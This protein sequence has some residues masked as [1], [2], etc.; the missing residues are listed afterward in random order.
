MLIQ[1]AAA[2]VDRVHLHV[3]THQSIANLIDLFGDTA[4][5]TSVTPG[6]DVIT[7]SIT[8]PNGTTTTYVIAQSIVSGSGLIV[9]KEQ[10]AEK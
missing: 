3:H 5:V 4:N 8:D 9:S 1:T 10:R 6:M 2:G 7:G